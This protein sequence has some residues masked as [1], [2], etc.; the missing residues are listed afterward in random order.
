MNGLEFGIPTSPDACVPFVLGEAAGI[1]GPVGDAP[2]TEGFAAAAL[3]AVRRE[4]D[5]V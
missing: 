2:S 4:L 1:P 5:R 3:S